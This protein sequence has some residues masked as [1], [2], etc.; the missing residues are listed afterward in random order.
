MGRAVGMVGVRRRG[1][2]YSPSRFEARGSRDGSLRRAWVRIWNDG[3]QAE[4]LRASLD[5]R[6]AVSLEAEVHE[7]QAWFR[8]RQVFYA[9]V[10][11][12]AY[13][14]A[15][16]RTCCHDGQDLDWTIK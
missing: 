14:I 4:V 2:V 7:P 13:L 15:A 6:H 8:S 11:M 10:A 9:L 3:A 16:Y 1:E 12:L 5:S